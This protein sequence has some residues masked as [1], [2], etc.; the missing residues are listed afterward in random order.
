MPI[1][2]YK[3]L[4]NKNTIDSKTPV[5]FE[6]SLKSEQS[7]KDSILSHLR[8]TLARHLKNA[9]KQEIWMATCYAVR[10]QVIDRFIRTQENIARLKP[11]EFII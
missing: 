1:A 7:L 3:N 6:I 4:M 8:L 2:N 9:S 5:G 10:D 11:N